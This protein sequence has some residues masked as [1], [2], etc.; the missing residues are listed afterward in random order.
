MRGV[1]RLL[2]WGACFA[3][4]GSYNSL[5]AQSKAAEKQAPAVVVLKGAP[6][7]GVK[8]AHAEQPKKRLWGK[9]R[10]RSV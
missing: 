10:R 7:G 9:S 4:A 3:I 5:A 6:I 1:H 8:F 2:A